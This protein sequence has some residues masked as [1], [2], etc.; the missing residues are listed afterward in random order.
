MTDH[1]TKGAT[2]FILSDYRNALEEFTN[3]ILS[4]QSSSVGF[5][6][7]GTVHLELGQYNNAEVDFLQGL[8]LNPESF[9]LSL[10]IG[11]VYFYK[12]NY[13]EA[14]SHFRKALLSSTTSEE[15]DRL[16]IWQSKNSI[17]LSELESEKP[18]IKFIHNWIQSDQTV[19]ITCDTATLL[20]KTEYTCSIDSDKVAVLKGNHT[21][22]EILLSGIIV[23]KDSKFNILSHKVEFTLMKSKKENWVNLERVSSYATAAKYPT[24]TKKDFDLIERELEDEMKSGDSKPEGNDAMMHL[25]KQIYANANEETKRAMIKSFSTSGGTVLSTNWNEVKE[26]DYEGKDR[27]S[28]PD[29]QEWADQKK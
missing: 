9:E 10:K 6:Y 22:H 5:L 1:L 27:P 18:K 7:R 8:K 17:E 14:D 11:I 26:K 12:K 29:G 13:K 16:I 21:V 15:R 25:F 24:S 23:P 4:D 20:N 3:L 28:A 2:Y 19:I